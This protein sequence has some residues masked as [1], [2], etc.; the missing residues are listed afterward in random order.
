MEHWATIKEHPNY[1]VSDRGQVR[2]KI[3][4]RTLHTHDNN[5]YKRIKI[6]GKL[7][8]VNRLIWDAFRDQDKDQEVRITRCKDCIHR[9]EY[10]FCKGK[11]DDFYCGHGE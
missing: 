4:G 11:N 6:G 2:N 7:H 3:T 5:G 1:E 9:G 10:D 8:Y